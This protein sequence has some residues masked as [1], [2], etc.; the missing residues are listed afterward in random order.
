MPS[1]PSGGFFFMRKG[2]F[3]M[4]K[5]IAAVSG[6]NG[7]LVSYSMD[8]LGIAVTVLIGFIAIE[9]HKNYGAIL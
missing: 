4:E 8:D 9:H 3:V 6:V 7:T 1:T 2:S 5:W